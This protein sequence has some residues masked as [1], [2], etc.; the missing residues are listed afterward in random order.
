VLFTIYPI[1]LVYGLE[2]NLNPNSQ[3]FTLRM[4]GKA[5][6]KKGGKYD[7]E[8]GKKTSKEG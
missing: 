3:T 2:M 4:E 5:K 1:R 6:D 8:I 7:E